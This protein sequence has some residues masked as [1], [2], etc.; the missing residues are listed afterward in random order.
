MR[1]KSLLSDESDPCCYICHTTM[2]LHV[3]HCFPGS[4]R[5][6]VSDDEGCWCYL[7]AGHH[8]LS[9]TSVHHDRQLDLWLRKKC[10][11]AWERREGINDPEH[12][13]FIDRFGANYL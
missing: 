4:G 10:Q 2:N 8:N 5:R 7:C 13:A 12:K 6:E 9:N 1:G 11:A 3:H